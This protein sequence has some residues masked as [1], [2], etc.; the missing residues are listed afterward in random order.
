[1]DDDCD[2]DE[3]VVIPRS[4]RPHH[5]PYDT[6]DSVYLNALNFLK[7]V[8]WVYDQDHWRQFFANNAALSLWNCATLRDFLKKDFRDNS[9]ATDKFLLSAARKFRKAIDSG[10][11]PPVVKTQWTIYPN[12]VPIRYGLTYSAHVRPCDGKVLMMIEASEPDPSSSVQIRSLEV[13]R[14]TTSM[15]TLYNIVGHVVLQNVIG[16]AEL[17]PENG[18]QLASINN[19]NSQIDPEHFLPYFK[20]RQDVYDLLEIV[21][22]GDSVLKKVKVRLRKGKR[23]H[24]VHASKVVDPVTGKDAIL[25]Q[26]EDI[27]LAVR[28]Q[29]ENLAFKMANKYKDEFLA[30]TSH[31]LRTPL[32]GK[33]YF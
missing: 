10:Q 18:E 3:V 31:E 29:K 9:D 13:L 17:V 14:H 6:E 26:E 23:I 22:K 15:I 27:T 28:Q 25:V 19:K 8:V 16:E 30:N 12:G 21:N 7:T 1:M 2:C 20:D 11:T 5:E 24:L 32:H 4:E 33:F